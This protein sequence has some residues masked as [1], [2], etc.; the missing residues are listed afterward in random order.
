M[1]A[2]K[3]LLSASHKLHKHHSLPSSDSRVD[4]LDLQSIDN[5]QRSK[6]KPAT[7]ISPST[8]IYKTDSPIP[9][10]P[11]SQSPTSFSASSS[12]SN[13]NYGR[14]RGRARAKHERAK[15]LDIKTAQLSQESL[16]RAQRRKN[17]YDSVGS[18][19]PMQG[20]KCSYHRPSQDLLKD[21]YGTLPLNMSQEGIG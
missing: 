4:Y 15:S 21:N 1:S 18:L 11:I 10:L 6:S 3:R 14:S 19:L 8:P 16:E 9:G 7:P 20:Y 2:L 5:H 13:L 17:S 12:K